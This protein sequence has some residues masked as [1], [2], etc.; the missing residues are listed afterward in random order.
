MSSARRHILDALE[1][2]NVPAPPKPR[3]AA[4]PSMPANPIEVMRERLQQNGGHLITTPP[5]SLV[6]AI[7]PSNS[8]E[9]LDQ[10]YVTP[11][12]ARPS[13]GLVSKG[14]GH[15][16]VV[17]DV[18]GLDLCLLAAELAVVE[19]GAAW[20][21]PSRPVER[22]AALLAETLVVVVQADALVAS[23]HDAYA[24]IDLGKTG[25]GWFLGGPSKTA[26]IE[27][28]LVFGAHGPREMKLV[29]IEGDAKH[30]QM[31]P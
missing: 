16:A 15:A 11:S 8:R 6:E 25:F 24:R 21:V 22:A 31:E 7:G 29:V 23:L 17:A 3:P 5:A 13:Q 4:R 30:P 19:N 14:R 12:L 28:S 9:R 1:A 26:D 27:Q 10:V 2:A 20:H 18:R